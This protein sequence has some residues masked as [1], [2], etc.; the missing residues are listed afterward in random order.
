[1]KLVFLFVNGEGE[2][3]LEEG[4]LITWGRRRSLAEETLILAQERTRRKDP[5]NSFKKYTGGWNISEK[6]YWAVS[7][8]SPNF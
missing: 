1:M 5:L 7:S 4:A 3:Q 2:E 8:I 6:H